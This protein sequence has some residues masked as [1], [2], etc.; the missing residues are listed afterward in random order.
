MSLIKKSIF[1]SG[2]NSGI[3]LAT[4]KKYKAEG[5]RVGICG[6][7]TTTLDP[8][9]DEFQVYQL[10][11]ANFDEVKKAVNDFA[12]D[13]LD[14]MFANAGVGY[15]HKSQKPDFNQSRKIFDIN[16]NGVLN[17][18]DVATQIFYTQGHGH[19]AATASIAGLNGLPG[20]SAYSGSKA[21]IIRMCESLKIDLKQFNINVTCVCPG[22]IDTPLTQKNSHSMPF[23]MNVD[24]AAVEIY[25]GIARNKDNIYFPKMFSSIVRLLGLLPRSIYRM[26]ISSK[27]FNY[28]KK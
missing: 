8:L 26:I 11:V 15:A 19:L 4:A 21:A 14:I 7:N 5:Y 13:G 2:G 3:G 12:K 23:L 20:V 1:I 16:I 9:K 24:E 6:R 10:D 28:S 27:K 25:Y 17:M 18:F 22:F